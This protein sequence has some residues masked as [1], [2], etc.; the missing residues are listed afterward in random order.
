M[1][2][3]DAFFISQLFQSLAKQHGILLIFGPVI[4]SG[5]EVRMHVGSQHAEIHFLP[6]IFFKNGEHRYFKS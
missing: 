4:Y 3:G 2:S 1:R 6:G 5:D